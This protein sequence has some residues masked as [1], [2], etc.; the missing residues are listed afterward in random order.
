MAGLFLGNRGTKDKAA[1][2]S[3]EYAG[4]FRE[5][6]DEILNSVLFLLIGLEVLTIPKAGTYV[7]P[8]LADIHWPVV[9]PAYLCRCGLFGAR[10]RNNFQLAS[11]KDHAGQ[12][13]REHTQDLLLVEPTGRSA[14]RSGFFQQDAVISSRFALRRVTSPRMSRCAIFHTGEDA[15]G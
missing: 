4:I 14:Q 7:L 3:W 8:G 5:V 6:V 11:G 9:P 2:D 10:A 15:I 12:R 13:K 1:H